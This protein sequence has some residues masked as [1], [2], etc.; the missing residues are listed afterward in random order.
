MKNYISG[1]GMS[2]SIVKKNMNPH[3]GVFANIVH[4][5]D[6]SVLIKSNLEQILEEMGPAMS[7]SLGYARQIAISGLSLQGAM[8]KE[9]YWENLKINEF[10]L[11]EIESNKELHMEA[12]DKAIEFVQSYSSRLT[13]KMCLLLIE[14][15]TDKDTVSA[16]DLGVYYSFDQLLDIFDKDVNEEEI[17]F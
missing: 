6:D 15:V 14:K 3:F 17:P 8:D 9:Y 13:V 2:I 5:I 11:N 4:D 7:A 1:V 16:Y 12:Y 10:L